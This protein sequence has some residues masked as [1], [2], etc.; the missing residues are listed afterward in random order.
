MTADSDLS[1]FVV[2]FQKKYSLNSNLEVNITDKSNFQI[3]KFDTSTCECDNI[4]LEAHYNVYY[5]DLPQT[6]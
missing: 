3:T 5:E 6:D 1:S 4:L 2:G